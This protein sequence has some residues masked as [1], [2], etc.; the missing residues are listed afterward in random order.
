MGKKWTTGLRT[1]WRLAFATSNRAAGIKTSSHSGW[2]TFASA[3]LRKGLTL[4]QTAI[5]LGHADEDA[6][7][8]Y[9]EVDRQRLRQMYE[10]AL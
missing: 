9:I 1:R 3:L 2:R 5:L 7:A 6:T 10:D 4:E 8:T